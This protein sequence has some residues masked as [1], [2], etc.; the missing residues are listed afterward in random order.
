MPD[1]QHD[2]ILDARLIVV[3]ESIAFTDAAAE[4]ASFGNG[5]RRATRPC[6]AHRPSCDVH[7]RLEQA[8]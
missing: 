1:S 4:C 8:V 5:D 3:K 6:N 2:N 7:Y